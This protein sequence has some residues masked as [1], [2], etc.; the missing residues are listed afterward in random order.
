[1]LNKF[2]DPDDAKFKLVA[3]AIQELA[4]NAAKALITRREGSI[5]SCV[6]EFS[7]INTQ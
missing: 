7:L 6:S 5:F 1:M 2:S 4:S 3:G